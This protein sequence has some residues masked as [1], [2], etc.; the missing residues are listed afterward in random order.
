MENRLIYFAGFG[1]SGSGGSS[2]LTLA[3]GPGKGFE[4]WHSLDELFEKEK[5][6]YSPTKEAV[7]NCSEVFDFINDPEDKPLDN[8][9]LLFIFQFISQPQFAGIINLESESFDEKGLMEYL[10]RKDY[11]AEMIFA[12]KTIKS[13]FAIKDPVLR[14]KYKSS[15]TRFKILVDGEDELGEAVGESV[16]KEREKI[17]MESKAERKGLAREIL[18]K[19]WAQMKD[20]PVRTV[21]IGA[22]LALVARWGYKKVKNLVLKEDGGVRWL[23]VGGLGGAAILGGAALW[24]WVGGEGL[25]ETVDQV[26]ELIEKGKDKKDKIYNRAEQVGLDESIEAVKD[27]PTAANIE[28]LS[29]DLLK[30]IGADIYPKFTEKL[31]VSADS[32]N[33]L[34]KIPLEKLS[35]AIN[36]STKE[37][38]LSRLP[39]KGEFTVEEKQ[40]LAKEGYKIAKYLL[41]T[42]QLS[43][44][45][46]KLREADLNYTDVYQLPVGIAIG[47]LFGSSELQM[48]LVALGKAWEIGKEGA[49]E[50]VDKVLEEPMRMR[51]LYAPLIWGIYATERIVDQEA[52]NQVYKSLEHIHQEA[53]FRKRNILEKWVNLWRKEKIPDPDIRKV[54]DW[55]VKNRGGKSP[56]QFSEAFAK[57]GS[58]KIEQYKGI[59]Q[60]F[61]AVDQQA[62]DFENLLDL[63]RKA[64]AAT[65]PAEYLKVR[66]RA[67]GVLDIIRA[68]KT[69][70]DTVV[71]QLDHNLKMGGRISGGVGQAAQNKLMKEIFER[72]YKLLEFQDEVALMLRNGKTKQFAECF[73]RFGGKKE[74]YSLFDDIEMLQLKALKTVPKGTLRSVVEYVKGIAALE[75]VKGAQSVLKGGLS[76]VA[77]LPPAFVIGETISDLASGGDHKWGAALN[78]LAQLIPIVGPLVFACKDGIVEAHIDPEEGLV[79]DVHPSHGGWNTAFGAAGF[80]MENRML[81]KALMKIAKKNGK[82]ILDQPGFLRRCVG[83]NSI[84]YMYEKPARFALKGLKLVCIKGPELLVSAGVQVGKKIASTAA[85]E[86]AKQGTKGV[87]KKGAEKVAA[88]E[89]IKKMKNK[90]SKAFMEKIYK[91]IAKLAAIRGGKKLGFAAVASATGVGAIIGI[92]MALWSLYDFGSLGKELYDSKNLNDRLNLDVVSFK[93]KTES[94]DQLSWLGVEAS[95]FSSVEE[96]SEDERVKSI[97]LVRME[98]EREDG[99]EEDWEFRNGELQKIVLYKEGREEILEQ[100]DLSDFEIEDEEAEEQ[101]SKVA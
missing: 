78:D 86:T 30:L 67:D 39:L 71:K 53:S 47:F 65:D 69:S 92:P 32:V 18:G 96:F 48:G 62:R 38:D 66:N 83:W 37:L 16:D 12:L 93:P 64:A 23:G 73:E 22:G 50:I 60:Q 56:E 75:P 82:H 14:N 98:I 5:A 68:R 41:G 2:Q 88:N 101:V 10:N 63:Y 89:A 51:T 99:S 28:E 45:R 31:D 100:L 24:K 81:K 72:Q 59:L 52:Y 84:K 36:E 46:R 42:E 74:L 91:R 54:L 19:T 57:L 55:A 21:L 58:A 33:F 95:H 25:S 97:P 77:V 79:Y 7:L 35:F 61:Y 9:T 6:D 1:R 76:A 34:E 13:I 20:H 40:K 27:S 90:V 17:L 43:E 49:S 85:F 4:K 11:D 15:F 80:Y 87:V 26:R 94:V 70:M 29:L 3:K 8:D 44:M